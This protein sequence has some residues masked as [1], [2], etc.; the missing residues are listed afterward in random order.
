MKLTY[1]M[2]KQAIPVHEP[3]DTS[4]ARSRAELASRGGLALRQSPSQ[5]LL[6]RSGGGTRYCGTTVD[7][8]Y[9]CFRF[10]SMISSASTSCAAFTDDRCRTRSMSSNS[11]LERS[12]EEV[13][14]VEAMDSIITTTSVESA[15]S[16]GVAAAAAAAS[17]TTTA[18]AGVNSS[19]SQE[20]V[21][22]HESYFLSR[23]ILFPY[24]QFLLCISS[25]S[26]PSY[27]HSILQFVIVVQ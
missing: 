27:L 11:S 5:G 21:Q 10:Q 13:H 14:R 6:R 24:F 19:R 9:E 8:G 20:T 18:G 2:A 1:E 4:A 15:S 12:I 26:F 7:F 16:L 22:Y 25:S 23:L 17:V 3:L